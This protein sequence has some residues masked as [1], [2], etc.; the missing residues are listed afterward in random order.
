MLSLTRMQGV[1]KRGGAAS[2][3][4]SAGDQ[5][6]LSNFFNTLEKDVANVPKMNF[7]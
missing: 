1:I 7:N 4:L 6:L 3:N 5:N 2:A